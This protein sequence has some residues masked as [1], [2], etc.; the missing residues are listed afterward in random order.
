MTGQRLADRACK[1]EQKGQTQTEQNMEVH[2]QTTQS[3]PYRARNG[4][5]DDGLCLHESFTVYS[6]AT[7]PACKSRDLARDT[8]D[9]MRMGQGASTSAS[10]PASTIY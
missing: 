10:S 7:L 3:I 1:I 6:K 2:T 8:I 5:V 4:N 9:G